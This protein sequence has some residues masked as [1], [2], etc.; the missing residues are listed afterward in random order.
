[1]HVISTEGGITSNHVISTTGPHPTKK[2][3]IS[4]EPRGPRRVHSTRWG[5]SEAKWRDPCISQLSSPLLLLLPLGTPGLQPWPSQLGPENRG[6]SPWGMPSL[7]QSRSLQPAPSERVY[8]QNSAKMN[9]E[10]Y[11]TKKNLKK[12]VETEEIVLTKRAER[13]KVNCGTVLRTRMNIDDR[14]SF[15]GCFLIDSSGGSGEPTGS[16]F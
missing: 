11:K 10:S 4:T 8:P 7:S 9:Q 14:A 1:M 13:L 6:F 3:V 12:P 2:H 16:L 5:A 15:N